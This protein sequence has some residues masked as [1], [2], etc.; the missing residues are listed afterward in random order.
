MARRV[1]LENSTNPNYSFVPA[2]KTIILPHYYPAE[3]LVLITN[4]TAGNK[5]IYNFSDPVLTATV[6][7][8]SPSA[9]QTTIVLAYNTA[10]MSSTDKIS[11]LVDEVDQSIMP[12]ETL[13]DPVSK[14]RISTPQSL[15]DTDF[16]Y[17]LQ[18]T[19]W[20]TVNYLSNRST[21]YPNLQ[22]PLTVTNITT[23][24]SSKSA[25]ITFTQA[26]GSG[27]VTSSGTTLTGSSSTFTTQ[28]VPGYAIYNASNV[29]VGIVSTVANNT[30]L[31]LQASAN[32]ALS[33]AS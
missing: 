25:N 26:A 10:A 17:G 24:S 4:V 12:S 9:T 16:E 2:T 7:P 1:I 3:R 6:T 27:T 28:I 20:E 22:Q 32:V 18:P 5:V 31:Q 30:S 13:M 21:Y 23:T 19:K 15:I 11:V 29:F 14:L 8:G 33:G